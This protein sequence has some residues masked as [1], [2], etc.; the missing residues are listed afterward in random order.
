MKK[1]AQAF[2]AIAALLLALMML[3]VQPSGRATVYRRQANVISR[4]GMLFVRPLQAAD[5]CHAA[6]NE[7]AILFASPFNVRTSG[8]DEVALDIRGRY[9]AP[10]AVPADWPAGDWC[11]SLE[12]RI[13]ASASAWA[14]RVPA[15]VLIAGPREAA[16]AASDFI[17]RDLQRSGVHFRELRASLTLPQ[18]LERLRLVPEVAAAS[19]PSRPVIFIGLDGA[20]WELMDDYIRAG[21]MPT[22]GYLVNHGT[23]GVLE[24]EHPPLSPLLW[25]TMFTGVG[26][27]QHEILD[28]T[29]FNPYTHEREPI[30]SDERCVP[31]IWNMMTD[32][33]KRTAL[34][35]VWASY[36]AEPVRGLNV[37]DR[38]FTFLFSESRVPERAVYPD[39]RKMWARRHLDAAKASMNARRLR[40]YLPWMSDA[41]Y[42]AAANASNPYSQ[43][44]SGLVRILIETDVYRRLSMDY[45][46]AG[47]LPDLSIIYLQGTD[48]IGHIFAPFAPPQ[49]AQITKSDYERYSGVPALYFQQIDRLL[50]DFLRLAKKNDATIVIASDH[51]FRWKEGRPF[52]LSSFAAASAA[53]WHRNEGV[54]VVW[55]TGITAKPGHPER[56]GVRQLSA[57]L[58]ALAGIPAASGT[59]TTPFPGVL[60]IDR[61]VDY[62]PLFQRALPPPRPSSSN[63]STEDVAKL[64]ALGY[65]G[66]N[67]VPRSQAK[68]TSDTKT[69]GAFNNA[70]LILREQRGI[71]KAIK[72][73]ERALEIDPRLASAEWN[74]S[75]TLFDTGQQLDR[76]D[77]LLVKSLSNGL[78]EGSR[79]VIARSIQYQRTGK[80]DRALRLLD[81]AIRVR[82]DEAELRLFRGRYRLERQDCRGALDDFENASRTRP[83]AIGLA[84][85][86]LARMCLGDTAGARSSF[87]QSLQLDPNQPML[88]RYLSAP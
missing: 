42:D 46:G 7:G 24:T 10:R 75:E 5:V 16:R 17:L 47:P 56:A 77:G 41:E 12:A 65:I 71:P 70:G 54:F 63:A 40:E 20:D 26:P 44:A 62:K 61:Q 2:L 38:F 53:K 11:G 25:T 74:L 35:G 68:G 30:T 23:G 33:G 67:E 19:R 49:Q 64:K 8:G 3:R 27:L 37:T 48:T 59:E 79:F 15:E 84:S 32:A 73:F 50:A 9:D 81:E 43:P 6:T 31:A 39:L 34:F 28:F 82:N 51:G 13:A 57:T 18:G 45:L 58:A 52:Q 83:D 87:A 1:S 76:S 85:V 88:R 22:L 21:S 14:S 69:A 55:G 72:S 60:R 86:G 80:R 29:R 66:A 78:P 4:Q 36:A